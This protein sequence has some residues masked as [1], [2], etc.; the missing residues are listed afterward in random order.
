MK[1]EGF[2]WSKARSNNSWIGFRGIVVVPYIA[3]CVV[4]TKA[5][6]LN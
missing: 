2:V 3:L 6:N 1:E 4:K 5:P